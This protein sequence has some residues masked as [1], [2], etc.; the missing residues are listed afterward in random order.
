MERDR[1]PPRIAHSLREALPGDLIYVDR[2][3]EV[4]S[5]GQFLRG[6]TLAL[7]R[8]TAYAAVMGV[9]VGGLA[10]SILP[11]VIAGGLTVALLHRR[12]AH[13]R[14]TL[15]RA[16]ALMSAGQLI[17]ARAV[18]S[19]LDG[20]TLEPGWW[21]ARARLL[22]RLDWMD[23]AHARALAQCVR[24]C[25]RYRHGQ[26]L[27]DGVWLFAIAGRASSARKVLAAMPR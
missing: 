20:R 17:E 23:G 21:F 25:R 24:L 10:S 15:T 1:R 14:R 27:H 11:G 12:S 2:R 8:V 5:R 19:T 9:V 4:L 7:A 16:S 13:P 18:L 6:R 26:T 22:Y 3:G